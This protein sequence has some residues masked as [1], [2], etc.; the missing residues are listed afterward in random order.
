MT[1]LKAKLYWLAV[2]VTF[3]LSACGGESDDDTFVR[4]P[5]TVDL[6]WIGLSVTV[7]G[8]YRLIERSTK[9]GEMRRAKLV[10]EDDDAPGAPV[11]TVYANVPPPADADVEYVLTK[12]PTGLSATD[13]QRKSDRI[14]KAGRHLVLGR[15]EDDWVT[16]DFSLETDGHDV[17][18]R[19]F[20]SLL[21]GVTL[22]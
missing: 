19:L 9:K 16:Y 2:L 1:N 22:K 11:F 3:A 8:G 10:F 15:L 6:D 13:V 17:D 7:P 18:H 5:T 20:T 12:T 4:R 21:S 14:G